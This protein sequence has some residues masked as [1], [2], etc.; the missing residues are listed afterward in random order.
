MLCINSYVLGK[1]A[2]V[3]SKPK[4]AGE[5]TAPA[6]GSDFGDNPF[7]SGFGAPMKEEDWTLEQVQI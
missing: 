3:L 6:F 1:Q 2:S 4:L 7:G 5:S